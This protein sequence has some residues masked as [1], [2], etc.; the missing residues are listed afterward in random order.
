MGSPRIGGN[1]DLLLG[2]ALK[3]VES[4]G[5]EAEKIAICKLK[6]APC[7]E[8]YGCLKDGNCVIHDDMDA[9]YPKLLS[10]DRIVIASPIFFYG[11]SAQLKAFID[12]GQALWARKYVLKQELP[13][14]GRKGAFIAVGATKGEKLFDGSV[15]TIRFFFKCIGVTYSDELLIRGIDQKGEIEEHPTALIDAFNLG[16]R[17]A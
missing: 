9:L 3:G 15:L 1:T 12:R 10:A 7:A 5:A 8:Y 13:N 2:E 14:S 11:I 6:I 17:L 4:V 16:K